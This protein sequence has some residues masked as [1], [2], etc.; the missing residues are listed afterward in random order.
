MIYFDG[1]IDP[2]TFKEVQQVEQYIKDR[3]HKAIL[4]IIPS[5]RAIM[6]TIDIKRSDATKVI[7]SLDLDNIEV[8]ATTTLNTQSKMIH[9]PVY[10][11]DKHGPD[12]KEVAK[13]NQLT[14]DKVIELHT[15]NTYLIYM[16]GFMPGFP[17]LGGLNKQLHTPRREEPRTS[18]PAGSVGIANNQ[19][20]LYP[21]S[22]PGGW[23]II[24][25]TPIQVFD[26]NRNPMC[27]YQSGDYI[28][29]YAINEQVFK[30]IEEEQKSEQF[31]IEKW[32]TVR[33]EY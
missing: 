15:D 5:Y 12:L 19:T 10:Y 26:M 9:I 4:E 30:Q 14:T 25:Q 32:V 7:N 31:D 23:Q 3:N 13:H 6:L 18:I 22:S 11:G 20:G 8:D 27:L 29:F 28:K 1:K 16:L 2:D 17:F 21:K 24:G 33:N